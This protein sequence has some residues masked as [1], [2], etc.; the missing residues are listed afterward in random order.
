VDP[1]LSG[2]GQVHEHTSETMGEQLLDFDKELVFLSIFHELFAVVET[3]Q[4][5]VRGIG[6]RQG[7]LWTE[8]STAPDDDDSIAVLSLSWLFSLG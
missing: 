3:V 7:L 8:G 2:S 5:V 4:G 6:D 1:L